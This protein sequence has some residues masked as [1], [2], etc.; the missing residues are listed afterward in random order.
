[1]TETMANMELNKFMANDL[2]DEAD[3]GNKKP[4]LIGGILA[5]A[6][7][8]GCVFV[9]N[10]FISGKQTALLEELQTRQEIAVEGRANLLAAWLDETAQRAKPITASPLFQLFATEIGISGG[11][12]LPQALQNQL[13]YMQNAITSFVQENQLVGAYLIGPDGRA[14]LASAG[15]PGLSD[16]QREKAV[17]Q[18]D[19]SEITVSP[20]RDAS[21]D[22]LIDYMIP[23]FAPQATAGEEKG[24]V[25]GVLVMVLSASDA[26]NTALKP[27]KL[28]AE[29]QVLHLYQK[30]GDN[31]ALV[32]PSKTPKIAKSNTSDMG[33][34]FGLRPLNSNGTFYF[35]SGN[36]V[37]GTDWMVLQGLPQ[38]T[39]LSELETY[40]FSIYG[41]SGS[42]FLVVISI[43]SGIWFSL[44]SQNAK[45][46]ADQYK[47]LAQQINAQRRLLG[48]INGSI[49]DLIGLTD[50]QGFY[51]YA[52]PALA[53][54]TDF[55][56]ASI[57]GKSDRDL[58]GDVAAR[59]LDEMNQKV[60][61][62]GQPTNDIFEMDTANGVRIVRVEKS[63][64]SD[65]SDSF[66]GIVTVIGDITEYITF[67]RQKEEQGRK[68]ISILVRMMEENDPYLA[69]HSQRMGEL[70]NNVAKILDIPREERQNI[71][72][73]ANL[74]QIG[75]I[76]IPPEIRTKEGR[77][78]DEEMNIMK[79]HVDRAGEL[80]GEMDIDE[81]VIT[82]VTQMYE[83]Q[84]G[85]GYPKQL[86]GDEINVSA[87][88]L[89]MADILVARVSPRSYR[90]AITVEE[91]ME[92]FR[93][94]PEKYDP[95][96]VTAFDEFLKTTDGKTLVDSLEGGIG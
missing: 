78:T 89:G 74:S 7:A 35:T 48:S 85:S 3:G 42:F 77:L 31:Y 93:T 86:S 37:T 38:S 84:D 25:T 55:P 96:V 33:Q 36:Q 20:L 8:I 47:T 13:P 75:K 82:A 91:A 50:A 83:R 12:N 61:V 64:L 65:D 87:R 32:S 18:Y 28:D 1:M 15:A 67:Q 46:M 14:Y 73:S 44:K 52:N 30:Q 9:S 76:S 39:A 56:E 49:E 57:A 95:K 10:S 81:D 54:F 72:T 62:S 43:V 70:S 26:I 71:A 5:L 16:E 79:G 58:F 23:I 60:M 80:L 53:R 90:Q 27:S 22:L 41:L 94:N 21:D 29:G 66:M 11:G 6:L 88:I 69:G 68:T 59:K 4:L 45:D 51:V 40:K 2:P 63:K 19:R 34:D 92:V 24:K 17:S